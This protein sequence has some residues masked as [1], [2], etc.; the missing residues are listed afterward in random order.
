MFGKG[1]RSAGS[2]GYRQPSRWLEMV[3][4]AV[5]VALVSRQ[6]APSYT[7]KKKRGRRRRRSRIA[8]LAFL[9]PNLEKVALS[10]TEKL[11]VYGLF[12]KKDFQICNIF[13]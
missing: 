6:E 11:R 12:L 10:E 4:A 13:F 9:G 3:E 7:E 8:R 1:S 5:L 2:K